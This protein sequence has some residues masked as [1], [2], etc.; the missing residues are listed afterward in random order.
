MNWEFI[1]RLQ[2]VYE[3]LEQMELQT[4]ERD[5]PIIWEKV[6]A[7]SCAQ[8]GRML[9]QK[10][11]VDGEQ[12]ALACALHDSGRWVSGRQENH[13]PKGEELTRRFLK[14]RNFP[15]DVQ[16]QIVQAVVNHSQKDKIGTPLEELVKDA[17]ILDCYWYGD[18]ISK[19]FHV[20]RLQKVLCDL[21]IVPLME[22]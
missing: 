18:V 9:A 22:G 14:T 1:Q 11:Q 7:T 4:R 21:K 3:V 5:Y 2:D 8:I 15:L 13:A 12:A 19:E 10:R 16:E 6:H 20:A 17:D